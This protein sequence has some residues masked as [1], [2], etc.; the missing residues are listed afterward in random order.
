MTAPTHTNASYTVS[1]RTSHKDPSFRPETRVVLMLPRRAYPRQ[2]TGDRARARASS[3]PAWLRPEPWIGNYSLPRA[4]MLGGTVHWSVTP[5]SHPSQSHQLLSQ[6][7][8]PSLA[9]RSWD[10]KRAVEPRTQDPENGNSTPRGGVVGVT[11][12]CSVCAT[13]TFGLGTGYNALG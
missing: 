8:P 13:H 2:R 4:A 11:W 10:G 1:Y 6:S 9:F 3:Q 7:H 12:D 5:L